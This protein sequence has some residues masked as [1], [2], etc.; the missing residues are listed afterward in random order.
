MVFLFPKEHGAYGQMAFPAVTALMVGRFHLSAVLCALVVVA[1]FLAHEPLLV[2]LGRRG[3]RAR[4]DAGRAA[5]VSLAAFIAIVAAAG[6][7]ALR[8]MPP[9]ARWSVA[10]P[11]V[12]LAAV[13]VALA[14]KSEKSW[15]GE[16][17]VAVAFSCAA[18]PIAVAGGAS[19]GAGLLIAWA[20]ATSFV[21]ATLAVRVVILRVRGGGDPRGSAAT[22]RAVFI[23][24]GT[25]VAVLAG[26]IAR[27]LLSW[28]ALAFLPGLAI[29]VPLAIS[30][31]PPI[32]LRAVGWQ[33]VGSSV[34]TT[35]IL[36]VVLLLA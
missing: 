33:L 7:G 20:F 8:L 1:G 28:G 35:V 16:L 26:L 32:R 36:V 34:V 11:L 31:P 24:A 3:P 12:P 4:L 5:P 18:V 17:S 27:G 2:V 22:R 21:L 14:Q 19:A 13:V 15:F 29:A 10:V 30:P 6:L 9:G 25:T 23:I